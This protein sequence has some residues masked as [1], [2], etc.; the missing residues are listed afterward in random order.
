MDLR[1]SYMLGKHTIINPFPSTLVLKLSLSESPPLE[2]N[3]SFRVI[4][5]YAISL[6]GGHLLPA[7]VQITLIL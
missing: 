6:K 5:L 1:V 7:G 3:G 2:E 4:I